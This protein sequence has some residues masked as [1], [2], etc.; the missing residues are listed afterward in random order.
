[1]CVL[2]PYYTQGGREPANCEHGQSCCELVLASSAGV[3]CAA[4]W[5]CWTVQVSGHV[6]FSTMST[7]G[8][9]QWGDPFVLVGSLGVTRGVL[10]FRPVL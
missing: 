1:M 6:D 10:V 8:V 4:R 2:T 7:F 9:V 5:L 3:D